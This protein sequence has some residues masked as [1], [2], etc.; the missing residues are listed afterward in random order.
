MLIHLTFLDYGIIV[1][2]AGVLGLCIYQEIQH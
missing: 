1:A 2:L